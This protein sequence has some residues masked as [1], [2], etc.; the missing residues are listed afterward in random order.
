MILNRTA[1]NWIGI[2]QNREIY[3]ENS[4]EKVEMEL[5]HLIMKKALLD[6]IGNFNFNFH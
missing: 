5:Y 3:R 2:V 6:V 1:N 4:V